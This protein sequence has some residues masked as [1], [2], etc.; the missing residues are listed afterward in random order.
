[1]SSPSH[2]Y[3][4]IFGRLASQL[5]TYNAA[6]ALTSI[7][8]SSRNAFGPIFRSS[9]RTTQRKGAR[10]R[11]FKQHT[12]RPRAYLARLRI[13]AICVGAHLPPRAVGTPRAFRMLA[14][15]RRL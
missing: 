4:E 13:S 8:N 10:Q 2:V 7:K 5:K 3:T 11:G 9:N 1:L 12:P 14:I 15:S 6:T